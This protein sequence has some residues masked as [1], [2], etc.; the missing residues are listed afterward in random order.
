MARGSVR[1]RCQ[2]CKKET[3]DKECADKL[4]A[5]QG[6][7]AEGVPVGRVGVAQGGLVFTTEVGTPIDP[8][9]LRRTTKTLCD[10]ADV[11]PVSPNEL[12]RHTAALL[13]YAAGM[14]L[15][16]IADLLGHSSTRVLEA[17]YRH[18]ARIVRP[19]C[20][21]RRSQLRRRLIRAICRRVAAQTR[22]LLTSANR[23]KDGIT[24]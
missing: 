10:L 13:L 23:V 7:L 11:D 6:S 19:P 17:Y 14:A 12:G 5:L 24:A 9:N 18:R 15:D 2:R 22:A 16:E 8:S 21:A 4:T 1:V 20:R 3:G